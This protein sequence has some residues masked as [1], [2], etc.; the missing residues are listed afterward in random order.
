MLNTLN[1]MNR[2]QNDLFSSSNFPGGDPNEP[3]CCFIF[4]YSWGIFFIAV[5]IV[6]DGTN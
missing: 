5:M 3:K 4:P 2:A 1:N 6:M